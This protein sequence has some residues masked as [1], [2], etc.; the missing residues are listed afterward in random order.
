MFQGS[1]CSDKCGGGPRLSILAALLLYGFIIIITKVKPWAGINLLNIT[2][3]A[4]NFVEISV[5]NP[6]ETMFIG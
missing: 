5:Y 6:L 4:W 1:Y 2:R 3:S